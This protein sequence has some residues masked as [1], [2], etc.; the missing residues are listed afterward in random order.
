MA[1]ELRRGG[2][3]RRE[4]WLIHVAPR[5]MNAAHDEIQLVAKEAVVRVCRQVSDQHDCS[6]VQRYPSVVAHRA[7]CIHQRR[8][9]SSIGCDCSPPEATVAVD[10]WG[11]ARSALG[12]DW[13]K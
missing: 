8:T 12:V 7:H 11:C 9:T 6:G 1:E 4:R 13:V 5:R 10:R 3:K 2:K